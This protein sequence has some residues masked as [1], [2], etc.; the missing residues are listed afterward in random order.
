MIGFVKLIV[1]IERIIIADFLSDCQ[2]E[3]DGIGAIFFIES[4]EDFFFIKRAVSSIIT[5]LKL[6]TTEGY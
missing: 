6:I 4:R 5:N 2:A 3:P 1:D